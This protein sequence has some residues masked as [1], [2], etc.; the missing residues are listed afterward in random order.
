M[1][2]ALT[3]WLRNFARDSP[4]SREELA[5]VVAELLPRRH[6][7]AGDCPADLEITE[8]VLN[9][10]LM[11]TYYTPEELRACLQNVS[12]EN[13]FSHIF[14]YPFSIPQLAVLKEYLYKRYPNGFPESLLA[15]LNPLLPLITPE[16]ISTWR[17]SSADTLAAFLKSQPPDSLASAA[18][19]RYVELGNALNPTALDAIGTRYVCLL[20]ATELGAIDPPSLRLASLDPS[21]C[22]QETKNLLYQKAKEAFSGQHHLPAYYELILP[23]LGGAPAVDL[24]ALSKDDVNMNVTTFVTL[25]RESLMYLTPREVQGLLGMNLPELARWQDRSPVRDWIQLQRQSELDQLHVGLTGGTQEGYINI[26]TP[27]FPATSSAPLGAVAMA[28]HL[29]PALL[30][31]LLVVSVLS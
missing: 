20:N 15:N 16:E 22:S 24:K 19:K 21:A 27:K 30:L 2:K 6:K 31:S 8:A 18:I 23:Y 28:F 11:P 4:L 12:L 26:V 29:L 25:R 7:R 14:T 3:T 13:H 5:A 9:D 10:D 1:E 17:M